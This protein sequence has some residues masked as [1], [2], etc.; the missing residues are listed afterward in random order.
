MRNAMLA[1]GFAGL[2]VTIYEV[3]N[4]ASRFAEAQ[5]E[6]DA[7][8]GMPGLNPS[9][10]VTTSYGTGLYLLGVGSAALLASAAAATQQLRV[11]TPAAQ[12]RTF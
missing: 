3:S 7:V 11:Q 10:L 5:A 1:C 9:D 2:A 6:M 4:I 8:S 12:R